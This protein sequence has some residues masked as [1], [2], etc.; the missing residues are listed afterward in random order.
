MF[1]FFKSK[2]QRKIEYF[3]SQIEGILDLSEKIKEVQQIAK[4]FLSDDPEIDRIIKRMNELEQ[5]IK[6]GY[7][8]YKIL[9]EC[10]LRDEIREEVLSLAQELAH[11]TDLIR[12][13]MLY[14]RDK[15]RLRDYF[16]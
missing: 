1:G 4:E 14:L 6:D 11:L 12:L 16:K 10:D 15:T 5:K 2:K 9:L 7:E 13:K 8:K 3:E